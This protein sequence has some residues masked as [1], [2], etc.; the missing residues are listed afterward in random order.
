MALQWAWSWENESAVILEDWSFAW[1]DTSAGTHAPSSVAGHLWS[2]TGSPARYSFLLSGA[3]AGGS[4]MQLPPEAVPS[5]SAG[6]IAVPAR[7]V[8]GTAASGADRR[9]FDVRFS[10]G[11]IQVY[12]TTT[13]NNGTLTLLVNPAVGGT[14]FVSGP[15]SFDFTTFHY[16]AVKWDV[17]T[18]TWT[19]SVYVDG[20]LHTSISVVSQT[21]QTNNSIQMRGLSSTSL[22][23]AIGQIITFDSAA[24]AAETPRW[25][26]NFQPTADGTN[27]GTWVSTGANDFSVLAGP[28]NTATYTEEAT[29]LS[30]D[31]VNVVNGTINSQLGITAPTV[32]AVVVHT[33]STG[34]AISAHAEI[35]DGT[36]TTNG[37]DNLI[38][39]VNP[40]YASVTSLTKPSGGAW[41]GTDSP[42]LNYEIA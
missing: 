3:G 4:W 40:T 39:A 18:T 2:Y 31:K 11:S 20:V 22:G 35:G 9:L 1:S 21:A 24:D 37:T 10:V 33:V 14:A 36:S 19:F 5:G 17:S 32:D 38:D 28:L 41:T 26:T 16:Y 27:V 29:P 30:G 12:P 42:E 13:G 25:V 15:T 6:C 34:E 23:C 7:I 8:A